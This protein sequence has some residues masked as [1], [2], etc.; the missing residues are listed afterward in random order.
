MLSLVALAH[1]SQLFWYDQ[2]RWWCECVF[3]APNINTGSGRVFGKLRMGH[4][5]NWILSGSGFGVVGEPHSMEG[6]A[7]HLR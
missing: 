6:A 5:E 4:Q 1:H 7:I 3:F 2:A